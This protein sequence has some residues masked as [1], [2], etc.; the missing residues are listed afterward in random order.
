MP[1]PVNAFSTSDFATLKRRIFDIASM[2]VQWLDDKGSSE[3]WK[4]IVIATSKDFQSICS[5]IA[6]HF[7]CYL[8][9]ANPAITTS[10]PFIVVRSLRSPRSSYTVDTTSIPQEA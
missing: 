8:I 5:A 2:L 4:S 10:V 7:N 3:G 1:D 9:I 6:S